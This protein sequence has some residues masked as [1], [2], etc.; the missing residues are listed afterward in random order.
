MS[1][2][3]NTKPSLQG[4]FSLIWSGDSALQPRPEDKDLAAQ[5]DH[6]LETCRERG[7]WGPLLKDGDQPTVFRFEFPSGTKRRKLMDLIGSLAQ[8]R[9]HELA[10]LF[11]RATV[12]EVTGL[13]DYHVRLAKDRDLGLD[14]AGD[15]LI[16]LLDGVS[17]AIVL[18]PLAV[19]LLPLV[20]RHVAGK[21][22]CHRLVL[23]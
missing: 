18:E 8:E 11:F 16:D 12:R 9:G 4:R 23:R 20:L 3:A 15:D 6:T 5:Y 13:G 14:L 2:N 1:I 19:I 10:A 17:P 22:E 21:L 7:D